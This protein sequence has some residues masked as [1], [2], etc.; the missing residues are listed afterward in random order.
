MLA[1]KKSENVA[2]IKSIKTDEDDSVVD[3][4]LLIPRYTLTNSAVI[5]PVGKNFPVACEIQ[6]II[7][8]H[9]TVKFDFLVNTTQVNASKYNVGICAR[10]NK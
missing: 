1:I 3:K 4:P 5:F 10:I 8:D 6:I 9:K 2:N 7:K